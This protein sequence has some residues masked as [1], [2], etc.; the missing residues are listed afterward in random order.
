MDC[1]CN[2]D[3]VN[4]VEHL[5]RLDNSYCSALAK[6]DQRVSTGPI[7]S[8]KPKNGNRL[9]DAGAERAPR[10][11]GVKARTAAPR[12]RLRLR[13][14]VDLGACVVAIDAN[15]GKVDDRLQ[16]R[17]ARERVG[18][19]FEHRISCGRGWDGDKD[20]VG[21]AKRANCVGRYRRSVKLEYCNGLAAQ[22]GDG[23]GRGG[24]GRAARS[25]HAV[26]RSAVIGY[27]AL[28][29]SR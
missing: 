7:N 8:R 22:A 15:C 29:Q 16:P 17:A 14:L 28:G 4:A 3:N 11:L 20:P 19:Y 25:H 9:P 5:P 10:G 1:L 13:R 12:Q 18:K 21:V 6:F 23:Q 26:I 24:F 27:V 2:V